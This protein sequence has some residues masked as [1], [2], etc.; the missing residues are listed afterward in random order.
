MAVIPLGRSPV[1][2]P[3]K[4]S[5]CQNE[6]CCPRMEVRGAIGKASYLFVL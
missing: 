3:S 1:E 4:A 5:K 6:N 2:K